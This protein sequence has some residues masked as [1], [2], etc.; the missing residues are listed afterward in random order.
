MILQ[1]INISKSYGEIEVLSDIN[2]EVEASTFY[3]ISG[4]SGCGKTTLLSILALLDRADSGRVLLK[5]RDIT[6]V[7]REEASYIRNAQY[8]FIFQSYNMLMHLNVMENV[9]LPFEY[10]LRAEGDIEK[11]AS[12]WLERVGML[13][14]RD[15]KIHTLSG[16]E[17][18]RVAIARA[19]IRNPDIIFADEPTG[20]LD[21]K[22]S[23]TI[24]DILQ[25]ISKEKDKS[26][27][28]VSHDKDA[29]NYCDKI[30]Q[31]DKR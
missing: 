29:L 8:G 31:L 19:L 24:L 11:I 27:I 15:K 7:S 26:V 3:G 16:G 25:D 4:A 21:A 28:M 5:G 12:L 9:L 13:N 6:T 2:I 1:G 10:G 23:A 30:L 14:Y 17:Q 22:N 20:N 18:Q